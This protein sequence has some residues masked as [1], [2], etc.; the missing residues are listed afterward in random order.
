MFLVRSSAYPEQQSSWSS[1]RH[2]FGQR[3]EI[4]C[5]KNMAYCRFLYLEVQVLENTDT[6]TA[7][8]V[9]L[10]KNMQKLVLLNT[11]RIK[12]YLYLYKIK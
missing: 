10:S 9:S 3:F 6:Y 8:W 7:R 4:S 11:S 12:K 2:I 1:H 5:Q